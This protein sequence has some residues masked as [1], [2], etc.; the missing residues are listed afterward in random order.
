MNQFVSF[1][2]S[3]RPEFGDL[4]NK[5]FQKWIIRDGEHLVGN[6]VVPVGGSCLLKMPLLFITATITDELIKY[7]LRFVGI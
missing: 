3:F 1:G 4:R 6:S 2:S 7:L 5:S